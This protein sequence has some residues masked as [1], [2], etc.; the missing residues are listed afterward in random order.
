[1]LKAYVENFVQPPSQQWI[2]TNATRGLFVTLGYVQ[3]IL[4]PHDA[5]EKCSTNFGESNGTN[6]SDIQ[7]T[8]HIICKGKEVFIDFKNMLASRI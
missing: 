1:M 7:H 5:Y 2:F 4:Y 6:K 8:Y 3:E